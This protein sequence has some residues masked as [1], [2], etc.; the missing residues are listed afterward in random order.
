MKFSESER[1]AK[2][3]VRLHRARGSVELR[4]VAS[5]SATQSF[6]LRNEKVGSQVS[7]MDRC[8]FPER[9][10]VGEVRRGGRRG[11][12]ASGRA[13]KRVRLSQTESLASFTN[14]TFHLTRPPVFRMACDAAKRNGRFGRI[15]YQRGKE[16]SSRGKRKRRVFLCRGTV[17]VKV[18]GKAIPASFLKI[19]GRGALVGAIDRRE[20]GIDKKIGKWSVAP[21]MSKK[22][23]EKREQRR[24]QKRSDC[25]R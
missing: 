13:E 2:G 9:G 11:R 16:S 8:P 3:R 12:R 5:G 6:W 1:R 10:T 22:G 17:G 25:Q 24:F 7:G 4:E 21:P 14:R 20:R 15:Q 23:Q 18:I 19:E